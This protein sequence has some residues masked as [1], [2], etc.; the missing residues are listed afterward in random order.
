MAVFVNVFFVPS[1]SLMHTSPIQKVFL[2]LCHRCFDFQ[3]LHLQRV[4]TRTRSDVHF[5]FGIFFS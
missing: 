2:Y 5:S 1:V 3:Q 4:L